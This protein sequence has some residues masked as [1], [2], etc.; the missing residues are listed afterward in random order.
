[1][2]QARLPDDIDAILGLPERL[3]ATDPAYVAALRIVE[4]RRLAPT[5]P[6]FKKA[7]LNLFLAEQDGK[8]V[9]SISALR[10][11]NFDPD[12]DERICWFGYFECV[13]DQAVADAL[14]AQVQAQAAEWGATCVRGPRNVTRLEYMGLTVEGHDRR[15]PMLQGHHPAYYAAL[16]TGAGFAPHHDHLAYETALVDVTGTPRPIPDDLLDK[17]AEC[18]IEG[19]VVRRA[20]WRSM[21]ADLRA[22]HAV[23]NDASRSVPDTNPMSR[24]TFVALGRVYLAFANAEMLQL[25]FVNGEA[26]G[27]AAAFPEIN[28]AIQVMRGRVLPFG[29]IRGLFALRRAKTAAFKLIGIRP[30]YRHRGLHAVLIKNVVEGA[31][32]AGYRRIDGSIIDERNAPM[33]HIVQTI[34]MD[35]WRRYRFFEKPV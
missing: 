33:N 30:A 26:V 8:V 4:R 22:A 12:A 1:M 17:A 29:W 20:L 18:D 27:F 16:L 2:R 5:N 11:E 21:A 9:G 34:G 13:E 10:D 25:A 35:V 28:E 32:R 15:P 24:A 19:L 23:F 7:T 31:Q 3:H 14:I 6:F